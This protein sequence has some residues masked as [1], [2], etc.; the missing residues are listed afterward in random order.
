MLLGVSGLVLLA[1]RTALDHDAQ[2]VA[3]PLPSP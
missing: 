3:G 1:G 2:G